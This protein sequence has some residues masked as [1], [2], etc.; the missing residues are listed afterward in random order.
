L[1][2]YGRTVFISAVS[3]PCTTASSCRPSPKPT[4]RQS[5]A[6]RRRSTKASRVRIPPGSA[7]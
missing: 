2:L 4:R 1:T 7:L 6:R 3:R 5:V